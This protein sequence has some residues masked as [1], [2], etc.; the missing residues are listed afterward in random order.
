VTASCHNIF[1]WTF[2]FI[3]TF[4]FIFIA[5]FISKI[6]V[7]GFDETIDRGIIKSN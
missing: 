1:N 6:V 7:W 3:F 5:M 4:M 2:I